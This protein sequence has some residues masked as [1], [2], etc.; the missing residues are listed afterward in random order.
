MFKIIFKKLMLKIQVQQFL[1]FVKAMLHRLATAFE[2]RCCTG[3]ESGRYCCTV[4][5][6]RFYFGRVEED[7]SPPRKCNMPSSYQTIP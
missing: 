4:Y 1:Q 7:L 6:N 5:E 3:F 2:G